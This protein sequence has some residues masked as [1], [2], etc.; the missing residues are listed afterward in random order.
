[1]VSDALWFCKIKNVDYLMNLNQ[2]YMK[3]QK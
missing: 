1:M 3:T 2:L